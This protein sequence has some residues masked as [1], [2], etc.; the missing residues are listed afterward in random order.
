[1]DYRHFGARGVA[2]YG[3]PDERTVP[4]SLKRTRKKSRNSPMTSASGGEAAS[5]L[6]YKKRTSRNYDAE[7]HSMALQQRAILT[8]ARV[9]EA[10]ADVFA[11]SG[12][13]AA[14]LNDITAEAGA[15]KGALYFHF[16]SKDALAGAIVAEHESQWAPLVEAVTAAAPNPLVA[17]VALTYEFGVRLRDD[18]VTRAGIRLTTEHELIDADLPAPFLDWTE[19]VQT[20]LTEARRDSLLRAG[21]TPAPTA[22]AVVSGFYGV[23]AVSAIV[24]D[25]KDLEARLDE[26]W[27]LFLVGIAADAD[28]V[29]FQRLVKRTLTAVHR[30]S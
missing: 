1:V 10:A 30:S 5:I 21:V 19:S 20:L 23:Q 18:P 12:F 14:T 25:R 15:T 7:V 22:R 2:F 17:A 9:L 27:K 11:R 29:T 16:T 3:K 6:V 8:R 24:S 13:A 28:W 4:V 26:F